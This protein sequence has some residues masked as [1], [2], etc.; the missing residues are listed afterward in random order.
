MRDRLD[1]ET[2]HFALGCEPGNARRSRIDHVT[3]TGH[4]ERALGDVGSQDDALT[5]MRLEHPLLFRFGKPCVQRQHFDCVLL[6]T[7]GKMSAKLFGRI[8]NIALRGKESQD[9]SSPLAEQLV[10]RIAKAF[11]HRVEII[12]RASLVFASAH[13]PTVSN[14]DRETATLD[15]HDR[16]WPNRVG[17]VICILLGI[18]SSTGDNDS[19]IGPLRQQAL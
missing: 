10:D 8:A 9:I 16:C 1:R 6:S 4:G 11:R 14:I 19:Q 2:L 5:A 15:Q 18:D 3:N 13:R 12:I 7:V 17:E